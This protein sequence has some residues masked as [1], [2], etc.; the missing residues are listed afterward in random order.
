M[1]GRTPADILTELSDVAERLGVL[2]NGNGHIAPSASVMRFSAA[3]LHGMD[4]AP[5]PWAIPGLLPQGAALLCG[6]PKAG[7]SRFVLGL[8]AAIA[9]GGIA[10]S[11]TEVAQGGVLVL[12]LDDGKRRLHER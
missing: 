1:S 10:L 5:L 9:Y 12:A 3:D 2:Q 8:A 6:P 7:K 4:F 11:H